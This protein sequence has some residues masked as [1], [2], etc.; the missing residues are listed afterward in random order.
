M[1]LHLHSLIRRHDKHRNN[2]AVIH[3]RNKITGTEHRINT[4]RLTRRHSTS[5]IINATYAFRF[6]QDVPNVSIVPPLP[7][8]HTIAR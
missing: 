4:G 6:K 1:A 7:L 2:L 8:D 5:L 3:A